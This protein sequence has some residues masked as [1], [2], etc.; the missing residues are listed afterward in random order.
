MSTPCGATSATSSSSSS[1]S[2]FFFDLFPQASTLRFQSDSL[3][4]KFSRRIVVAWS[5][6]L[7]CTAPAITKNFGQQSSQLGLEL[8][9]R[10]HCPWCCCICLRLPFPVSACSLVLTIHQLTCSKAGM[11]AFGQVYLT[12]EKLAILSFHTGK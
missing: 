10:L 9:C 11:P 8:R 12:R 2:D 1:I 4:L 7:P 5:D 6:H 3:G